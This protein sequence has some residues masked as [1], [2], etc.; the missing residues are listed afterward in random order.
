M[1][2]TKLYIGIDVYDPIVSVLQERAGL[3]TENISKLP[4]HLTLQY[5]GKQVTDE[6]AAQ[7]AFLW[8]QEL[9]E[10]RLDA[11][12][13]LYIFITGNFDLYGKN[14][15]SLV[16]L[17]EMSRKFSSAVEGARKRVAEKMPHIAKSDFA[18]SP[19]ITLGE[20]TEMPVQTPG[21]TRLVTFYNLTAWGD[22]GK[23]RGTIEVPV[24]GGN[25][26]LDL[27]RV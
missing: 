11:S 1:N 5:G 4:H 3:K 26:V 17:C 20:A 8:K 27:F 13:D 21:L 24:K 23:V 25:G 16:V 15:D 6:D 10:A 18:F 22:D 9:L 2:A 12:R 19:H 14:N 7:I